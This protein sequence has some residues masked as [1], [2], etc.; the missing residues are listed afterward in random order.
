[1]QLD[2]GERTSLELLRPLF[3]P[4]KGVRLLGVTI[5]NLSGTTDEGR[6]QLALTFDPIALR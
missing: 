6:A 1:M 4:Q 2:P 5:R 3:P